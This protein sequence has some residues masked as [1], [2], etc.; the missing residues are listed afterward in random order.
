MQLHAALSK[1]VP[2]VSRDLYRQFRANLPSAEQRKN[3]NIWQKFYQIQG[4]ESVEVSSNV[5]DV[6]VVIHTWLMRG[7]ACPALLQMHRSQL[8]Q[9]LQETSTGFHVPVQVSN[10]SRI[11]EMREILCFQRQRDWSQ[12][13][14]SHQ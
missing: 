11:H 3:F 6:V 5:D 13:E 7:L 9:G 2:L 12:E 1:R 14:E 10:T 4:M 8:Y